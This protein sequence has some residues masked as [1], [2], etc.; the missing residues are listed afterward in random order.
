MIQVENLN[1]PINSPFREQY[2]LEHQL[3]E[4]TINYYT[5]YLFERQQ[6]FELGPLDYN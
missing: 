5:Y 4:H 1:L 3:L 2:R 6:S